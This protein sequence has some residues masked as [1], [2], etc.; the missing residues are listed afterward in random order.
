MVRLR[1][2]L[3]TTEAAMASSTTINSPILLNPSG[4][5]G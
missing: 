4:V 3:L 2:V 1:T 5:T